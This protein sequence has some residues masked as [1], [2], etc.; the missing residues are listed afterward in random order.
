MKKGFGTLTNDYATLVDQTP[1]N[2]VLKPSKKPG[3][4]FCNLNF[5]VNAEIY[6]EMG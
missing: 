4:N 5:Q 6:I 1:L 2:L 3:L